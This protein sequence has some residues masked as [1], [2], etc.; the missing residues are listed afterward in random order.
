M[1]PA[2][3]GVIAISQCNMSRR[4]MLKGAVGGLAAA[5]PALALTQA[6]SAAQPTMTV[7]LDKIEKIVVNGRISQGICGCG[8]RM[9]LEEKCAMIAKMGL[10]SMDF[11]GPND[12][13]TMKKYGL[14]CSLASGA[15]SI[16][17]GWNRK[18]N[19]AKLIDDMKKSIDRVSEAGWSTVIT[20]SGNRHKGRDDKEGISDE[21]GA[22][23]C[24][25]GLKQVARSEAVAG[26][27]E[28]SAGSTVVGAALAIDQ[29]AGSLKDKSE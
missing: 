20:F 21:E 11:A 18:E 13:P 28:I 4:A 17:V 14:V 26:A 19:H 22:R 9:S 8:L 24:I 7:D 29:V 5:M 15:G 1:I 12:W 25:E 3:N 10:R 2:N 23:N 16:P 27:A 6:S